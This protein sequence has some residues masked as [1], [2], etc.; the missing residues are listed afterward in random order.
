MV[1]FVGG[2]EGA[3]H[4]VRSSSTEGLTSAFACPYPPASKGLVFRFR[5]PVRCIFARGH[6]TRRA[7]FLS[8]LWPHVP[9]HREVSWFVCSAAMLLLLLGVCSHG[10]VG[11]DPL[12][13]SIAS[14]EGTRFHTTPCSGSY[15]KERAFG[16]Y[17]H[18]RGAS[19]HG[20]RR[21]MVRRFASTVACVFG[22]RA[23]AVVS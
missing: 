14:A 4:F 16:D 1:R 6:G 9:R 11:V 2:T 15:G 3:L 17:V 8:S 13:R 22:F 19:E 20:F 12:G 23:L 21:L 10:I 7:H 5:P 18:S